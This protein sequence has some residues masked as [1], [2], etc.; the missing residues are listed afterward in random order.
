MLMRNEQ[1]V[2]VRRADYRPPVFLL[3]RVVLEF[4]L[5]PVLTH[6]TATLA[7]RRN[8]AFAGDTG[9]LRLN[10]EDLELVSV[11]LD[12]RALPGAG[13]E[14]RDDGL[15]I[16]APSDTFDVKIVNRIRP[17]TNTELMGV[18]VSNGNFFSQCEAEGFRRITFYP[19]RPDVMTPFRVVLRADQA[20]YPALLSNG[21]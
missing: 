11:E 9:P 18:F 13:Y 16:P 10:G 14:L 6:V 12:G 4:D 17:S 21:N 5:D 15:T 2:T 20:K 7:V 3:D 8:P 1:V 19:D